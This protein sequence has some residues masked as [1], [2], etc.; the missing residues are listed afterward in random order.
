MELS[1]NGLYHIELQSKWGK[2]YDVKIEGTGSQ[3]SIQKLN[4]SANIKKEFFDDYAMSISTYL[5]L[6]PNNAVIYIGKPII[7]FD[8]YKISE[9]DTEKVFI[10]ESL[11]DFSKTY[12]YITAKRYVFEIESGIK[13]YKN[14]LEED[15]YFKDIR[16]K[17]S[18]KIKTIDDFV[19]DD[20]STDVK[21]IDI[22]T[23]ENYL[24]S[25]EKDR[26][27]TL[28]QYKAFSIQKQ[29]NYEDSQRSLYEQTIRA[30]EAERIY[31][32]RRALLLSQLSDISNKEAQNSHVN[33]ILIHIEN[34]IREL[35]GNL[36][37]DPRFENENIPTFEELYE[38]A[39]EAI[40]KRV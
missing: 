16:G 37:N 20:I 14:I 5:M 8:P 10:P 30:K 1:I 17:I 13:R 18:K 36:K 33:S 25:L 39:E 3:A 12:N 31:E 15:R 22:L 4:P 32:E 6:L 35:L 21:A 19:I 28:D 7:A 24:D 9:E 34:C 29:S 26:Q 11:I 40:T 38:A 27:K 23:T 2:S